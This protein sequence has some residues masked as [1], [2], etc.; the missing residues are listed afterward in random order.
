M[1]VFTRNKTEL[2]RQ[3]VF[4]PGFTPLRIGVIL[5]GGGA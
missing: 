3:K 1:H 2:R 5:S 4:I